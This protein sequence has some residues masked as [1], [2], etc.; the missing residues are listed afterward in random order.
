MIHFVIPI[1]NRLQ[2]TIECINSIYEFVQS[3]F[4]ITIVNDGSSDDSTNYISKHY[5]KINLIQADGYQYWTGA[6][7]LGINNILVNAKKNDFVMTLNNDVTLSKNTITELLREAR[8]NR[9]GLFNALSINSKDKET[10]IRSG[11]I[12]KSWFFNYT[13]SIYS[14]I[15]YNEILSY[16]PVK[17]DLLTGR[18]I[19]LPVEI[20]KEIGNF[21][22]KS[23]RHYGGDDE[24][25]NR[26]SKAGWSLYVVPKAIVY[27]DQE[28]TGLNPLS[29]SL[30]IIQL[31]KSLYSINSTNNIFV[32]TKLS[33]RMVPWYAIPT[34]LLISYIKI[35]LSILIGLKKI[36]TQ[37]I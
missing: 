28:A 22:A 19:L 33:F 12:M 4:T 25:S 15:L 24:F 13:S 29:R 6:I 17:V 8:K 37:K 9:K 36:F 30:S 11:S 14:G 2:H 3:D 10:S 23:F 26:A 32:R 34:Y 5:P 20:F 35:F 1:Y 31:A 27:V 16:Q 18:S 7:R 21:D